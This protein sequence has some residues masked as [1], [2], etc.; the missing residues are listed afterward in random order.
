MTYQY[1]SSDTVGKWKSLQLTSQHLKA[2]SVLDIGCNAGAMCELAIT[3]GATHTHGI[4]M[5]AEMIEQARQ[6]DK[7]SFT[8]QS[9]KNDFPLSE[10]H[11]EGKFDIIL[12]LSAIHYEDDPLKL[13]LRI[14]ETLTDDGVFVLECGQATIPTGWQLSH[15]PGNGVVRHPSR[16]ALLKL[17]DA[18]GLTCRYVGPSVQQAGDNVPRFV[19]HCSRKQKTLVLVTG[20]SGAGKTS[21]CRELGATSFGVDEFCHHSKETHQSSWLSVFDKNLSLMYEQLANAP[22]MLDEFLND[23]MKCLPDDDVVLID[24][25]SL[26]SPA[27]KTR[28]LQDGYRVWETQCQ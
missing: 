12:M 4:D 23:L 6:T 24:V 9:W 11:A 13:L 10:Q 17:L 5:S 26:I 2:S 7:S 25:H 18:A 20:E 1:G 27:L 21:L 8:C 19:F 16:D 28:A 22:E 14:C 15:R 3:G